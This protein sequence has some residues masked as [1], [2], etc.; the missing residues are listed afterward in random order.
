M[1]KRLL[2]KKLIVISQSEE[3]SLEVPFKKGLNII[4]GGNKTGKSSLIKSIFTTLGCEC[5]KVEK[6]WKKLISTYLLYF[7]YGEEQYCIL[8]YDKEFSIMKEEK[9]SYICIINTNKFQLFCDKLMEIFEIDMQCVMSH[10][11]EIIN[12]TTPLLFRFQYIDQD[13]GWSDIGNEFQNVRYI[14]DWKGDTNK[15]ITGYL[16]NDYY[17]LKAEK[18]QLSNDKDEKSKSIKNNETFVIS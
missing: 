4:L 3:S 13:D 7:K 2:L 8:R 18:I 6:D 11:S 15:F 16:D 9:N 14:K 1:M 10:N 12:V 17:R 5:K